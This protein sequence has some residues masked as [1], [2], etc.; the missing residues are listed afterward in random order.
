MRSPSS[1]DGNPGNRTSSVRNRTQPAS[2]CPHP[3]AASPSAAS[4]T[5]GLFT[6]AFWTVPRRRSVRWRA[7]RG[8]LRPRAAPAVGACPKREKNMRLSELD[9]ELVE[10]GLDRDDV[11]LELQL[12]IVEPRRDADQLREGEDRHGEVAAGCLA[13]LRLPGVEGEMANGGRRPH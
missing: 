6:R 13:D 3:A 8:T 11:P 12:R 1:S 9:L 7:G 2:N 10:D 5:R 4:V